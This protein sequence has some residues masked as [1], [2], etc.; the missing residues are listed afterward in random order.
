MYYLLYRN[1]ENRYSICDYE[2]YILS[3]SYNGRMYSTTIENACKIAK[4][5]LLCNR[6]HFD[7]TR[8][9]E[10]D[11]ILSY[12]PLS[13]LENPRQNYPELFI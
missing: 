7:L 5:R 2:G 8:K 6:Y 11:V 12:Y 1:R 3:N 4:V 9:F 10:G 13:T